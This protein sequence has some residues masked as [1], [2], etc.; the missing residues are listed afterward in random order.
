[1][2][3]DTFYYLLAIFL[4]CLAVRTGYE[5]LKKSGRVDPENRTLFIVIFS[6]MCILWVSWFNMCT[7]DPSSRTLPAAAE[8]LG[9]GAVLLGMALAVGALVQLRGVENIKHLVT[10]GLFARLRHPMYAGFALWILGWAIYYGAIISLLVG[11]IGIGNIFYWRWLE[12]EK[13]ESLY[14]DT[15]RGYRLRTWF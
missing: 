11:L 4:L 12:E 8:W 3:D 13:L 9:L 1:M 10:T 14:G 7:V 6:T 2:Q 15:Y 5:L